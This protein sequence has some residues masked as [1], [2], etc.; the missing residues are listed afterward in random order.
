MQ[1]PYYDPWQRFISRRPLA[2]EGDV[3]PPVGV[4]GTRGTD[5]S[6]GGDMSTHFRCE[7]GKGNEFD[8]SLSV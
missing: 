6:H 7:T 4:Q 3:V 1:A 5:G 8:F 2:A